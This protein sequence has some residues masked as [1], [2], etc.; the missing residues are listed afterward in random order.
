MEHI[1]IKDPV[2]YLSVISRAFREFSDEFNFDYS[3]SIEDAYKRAAKVINS[4]IEHDLIDT[5]DENSECKHSLSLVRYCNDTG[6]VN[7]GPIEVKGNFVSENPE[8]NYYFYLP[9]DSCRIRKV[10]YSEINKLNGSYFV[11]LFT[12]FNTMGQ[13]VMVIEDVDCE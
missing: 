4:K 5:A 10:E 2:T 1:E 9:D 6:I 11:G 3:E 13:K 12:I 7:A 8:E